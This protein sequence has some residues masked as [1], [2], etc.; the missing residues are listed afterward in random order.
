MAGWG[1]GISNMLNTGFELNGNVYAKK[2]LPSVADNLSKVWRT[3]TTKFG[4]Y[5]E[6]T[7]NEQPGNGPV[8]GPWCLPP[9]E[10][11]TAANRTPTCLFGRPP[12]HPDLLFLS[13][14]PSPSL[15]PDF[16]PPVPAN[17]PCL[18]TLA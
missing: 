15:T 2:T 7:W 17:I 18:S 1:D 11:A 6:R 12:N 8:N 14:P 4:F 13:I 5:W 10:A 16:S 3:H 9:W